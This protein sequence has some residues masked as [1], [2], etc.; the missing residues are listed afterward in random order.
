MVCL[1]AAINPKVNTQLQNGWTEGS[2][3]AG[4]CWKVPRDKRGLNRGKSTCIVTE[5]VLSKWATSGIEKAYSKLVLTKGKNKEQILPEA[6]IVVPSGAELA[7][8]DCP[9]SISPCKQNSSISICIAQKMYQINYFYF[10][11]ETT[12][13]GWFLEKAN[14]LSV[15]FCKV[16]GLMCS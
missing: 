3:N 9:I 14:I 15:H 2:F 6:L 16:W 13:R 12:N 10:I 5:G 8:S 4:G 1:V 7:C 11:A